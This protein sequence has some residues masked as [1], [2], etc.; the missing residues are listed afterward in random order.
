[1]VERTGVACAASGKSG[2]FLALDWCDGTPLDAAGAAQ[3]RAPCRARRGD[4]RRL[5]LPAPRHLWRLCP[6][7]AARNRA[8][9]RPTSGCPTDV[10]V[11]QRPGLAGD[12]RAGRTRRSFT[13]AMMRAAEAKARLSATRPRDR[14]ARADGDGVAA[15]RSNGETIEADAVVIAMGPWSILAAALAAACRAVYGLQRPQPGLRDRRERAGG[16]VVPRVPGGRRRG[17]DARAVSARRR[18]HLCL[19]DLEREPAADRPGRRSART[20]GAIERLE[21]MCRTISPALAGGDDHRT[22]GLLPSG[23][24]GRAAADRPGARRRRA[25]MSRPGTASGASSTRPRPARRSPKL[26]VDGAARSVDLRPF[27]AGRLTPLDPVRLR[28]MAP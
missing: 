15:S 21:A 14:H 11:T 6:R 13:E 26:I 9:R 18:H 16:G 23:R 7:S 2:G 3:L 4:R 12:D 28:G 10:T 25:P 20:P 27:D 22:P 8:R 19:R 17:A 5:G 1:M 24:R